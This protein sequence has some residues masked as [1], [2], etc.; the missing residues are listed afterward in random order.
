MNLNNIPNKKAL[1]LFQATL[2][3]LWF[4]FMFHDGPSVISILLWQGL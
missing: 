1:A 4:L 2:I 3:L